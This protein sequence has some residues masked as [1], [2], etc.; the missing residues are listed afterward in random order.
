MDLC[1]YGLN[2]GLTAEQVGA[3]AKLSTV[4]VERV[5]ADIAAKR[6]ATRYLHLEPQL[7]QP[8]AEIAG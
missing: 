4:E 1:L 8:V 6:R 5:F 3:A 7:V 2:N